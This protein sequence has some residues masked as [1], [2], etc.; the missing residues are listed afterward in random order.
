MAVFFLILYLAVLVFF[1]E[2]LLAA[3]D[4]LLNN[5]YHRDK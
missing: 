5:R 4:D 3:F 1:G 2:H